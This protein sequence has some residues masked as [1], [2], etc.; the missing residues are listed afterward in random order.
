M[1]DR[2]ATLLEPVKYR[3]VTFGV[4]PD[5]FGPMVTATRQV[6]DVNAP[7]RM[8]PFMSYSTIFGPML[9]PGNESL[10]YDWIFKVVIVVDMEYHEAAEH[11]LVAGNRIFDPHKER[12]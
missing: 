11:F 12:V 2:L 5:W 3:D 1:L 4:Q 10:F 7:G 8:V 9:E 6:E